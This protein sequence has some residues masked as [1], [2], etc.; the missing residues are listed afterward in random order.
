M[1]NWVRQMGQYV[2]S[3]SGCHLGKANSCALLRDPLPREPGPADVLRRIVP[4]VGVALWESPAGDLLEEVRE[5][6]AS[7]TSGRAL[8][9]AMVAGGGEDALGSAGGETG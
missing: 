3:P 4:R 5:G 8:S 9:S 1:L 7:G 2:T 6:K